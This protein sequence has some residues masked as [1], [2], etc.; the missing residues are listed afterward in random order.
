MAAISISSSSETIR[1]VGLLT[2]VIV[3][4]PGTSIWTG[5]IASSCMNLETKKALPVLLVGNLISM[6]LMSGFVGLVA[7]V[8]GF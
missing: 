4:I 2:F 5:A 7:S 8:L 1:Y 6:L 3:P